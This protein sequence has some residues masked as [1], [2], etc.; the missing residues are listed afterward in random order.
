MCRRLFHHRSHTFFSI[1]ENYYNNDEGRGD[2]MEK[3]YNKERKR[4]MR[5]FCVVCVLKKLGEGEK[6]REAF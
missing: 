5:T 6:I 2:K 3:R 1:N 4:M